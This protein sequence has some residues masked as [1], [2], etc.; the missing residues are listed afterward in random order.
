MGN[1]ASDKF[2]PS[3]LWTLEIL[4]GADYAE[5]VRLIWETDEN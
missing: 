5:A 4:I 2:S 1:R 3:N